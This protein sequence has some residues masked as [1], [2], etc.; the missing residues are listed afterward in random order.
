M[1]TNNINILPAVI[2][3]FQSENSEFKT[4]HLVVNRFFVICNH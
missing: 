2:C 1:K 4:M 3:F